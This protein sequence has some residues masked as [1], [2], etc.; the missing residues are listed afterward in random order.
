MDSRQRVIEAIHHREAD[1]VPV[2]VGSNITSGIHIDAY[3]L[4]AKYLDIDIGLPKVY[5][6]FQ[7]LARVEEPMRQWLRA[8]IVELENPVEAW[9]LKNEKWK[10]WTTALGNEVLMP[11]GFNPATDEK[12]VQYILGADGKPVA[13]MPPG[14]LYFERCCPN[15]LSDDIVKMDPEV[16]RKS[17]P[18]YTQ[19]ELRELEAQGKQLYEET[20]YAVFGGFCRGALGTYGLFAGHTIADWLL[21]LLSEPDYADEIL[22]ATARRAVENAELYLQAVGRYLEVI[23]V[24]GFDFGTQDR[25]LFNPEIFRQLYAPHYKTINDYIHSHCRA[26]TFFHSCGSIADIIEDFVAAGVDILNPVQT[27]A[28]R[29]DPEQLKRKFG[30]RLTFWGGGVDTQSMLPFGNPEAVE[31]QVK[32][33]ISIFAPGGGFVFSPV[34][35]IQPGV[36]PENIVAMMQAVWACGGYPIN[37]K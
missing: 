5:E 4:L 9:G 25:E 31:A 22:E 29:M 8:D 26:K 20:E 32:E 33:R 16:W 6:Q 37:I 7:M 28:A 34:H 35:N 23:H 15:G 19:E 12:G 2:G 27:S 13:Y 11:G 17:L 1:R 36:P 21:I 24:S 30:D 18:L 14:A 3:V 10:K